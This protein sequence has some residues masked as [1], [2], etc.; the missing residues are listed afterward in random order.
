MAD[1]LRYIVF[2]TDDPSY[3]AIKSDDNIFTGDNTFSGTTTFTGALAISDDITTT[4]DII[5][6]SDT[7]GLKLGDDQDISIVGTGAGALSITPA[8]DTDLAITFVGTTSSGVLTWM[9]DED[10]FEIGD[11]FFLAKPVYNDTN[12]GGL[13]LRTGGTAP[14]V[15]QILDNDGDTTGIYTVGFDIDEQGSGSMEI[16]HDYQEGSD[17]VFHVHWGGNTAPSGTDNVK[18]QLIYSISRDGNTFPDSTPVSADDTA[19]DTQYEWVRTDIA[20]IEGSTGGVDGGNIKIGD[21]FNFTLKRIA[22]DGD[23]YGGEALVASIGFHYLTDTMGSRQI[24]TK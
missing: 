15:V 6:D 2:G 19:Y 23:A 8:A 18:W 7:A 13:V 1:T 16:P 20:T 9:E 21:Q 14:G 10:Y 11:D 17:L 3:V 22:A 12:V 5:I 24:G 4:H